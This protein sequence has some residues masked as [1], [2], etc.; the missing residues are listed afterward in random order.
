MFR[1]NASCHWMPCIHT[2]PSHAFLT[3]LRLTPAPAPDHL[4]ALY[5]CRFDDLKA[6]LK[7]PVLFMLKCLFWHTHQGILINIKFFKLLLLK[8]PGIFKFFSSQMHQVYTT[9]LK[10]W[11]YHTWWLTYERDLGSQEVKTVDDG[12]VLS[13]AFQ[14]WR[15]YMALFND[16]LNVFKIVSL[17]FKLK[18]IEQIFHLW[19]QLGLYR[20]FFLEVSIR[21]RYGS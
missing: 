3:P 4:T 7:G 9:L 8:M 19:N 17:S 14:R 21:E 11:V 16:G 20:N 18:F 1:L 15:F 6:G 5:K 13:I 10:I 2:Y 12:F